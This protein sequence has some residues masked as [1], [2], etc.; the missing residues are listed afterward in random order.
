MKKKEAEDG[1][2][3]LAIEWMHGTGYRPK[4]GWYPSFSDFKD[5]L[6]ANHRSL[7]LNFRSEIGAET[8]AEQWFEAEIKGYWQNRRS[9]GLTT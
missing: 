1:I 8:E 4:Q 9:R 2:K 3:R 7:Y 6:E 5:W